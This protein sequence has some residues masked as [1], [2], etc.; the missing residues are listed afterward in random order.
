MGIEKPNPDDYLLIYWNRSKSDTGL[1][2]RLG[3][4]VSLSVLRALG[5]EANLTGKRSQMDMAKF[6][7]LKDHTEQLDTIP[8]DLAV[9]PLCAVQG[10]PVGG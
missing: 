9:L 5:A 6:I 3:K 1:V 2:Y 4:F 7:R 8:R 10:H